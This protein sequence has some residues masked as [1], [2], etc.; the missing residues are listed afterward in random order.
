M[1][2]LEL[3]GIDDLMIQEH[4]KSEDIC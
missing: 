2:G 4:Y 3:K 1:P